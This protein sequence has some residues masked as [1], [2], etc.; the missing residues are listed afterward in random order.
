MAAGLEIAI[1]FADHH[2]REA[3]E[4][5]RTTPD[6]PATSRD[7]ADN[8]LRAESEAW[9][10][11]A[12]RRALAVS[13]LQGTI[14]AVTDLASEEITARTEWGDGHRAA[15]ADLQEVLREFGCIKPAEAG[16]RA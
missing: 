10:R 14:Q 3:G 13:K 16:E 5:A 6:N 12:V 4:E 8:S 15:I 1:F 11:K 7:A 9:R 2:L